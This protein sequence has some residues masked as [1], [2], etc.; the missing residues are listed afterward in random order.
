MSWHDADDFVLPAVQP[1]RFAH[2]RRIAREA[3][4]PEPMAQH[5]DLLASRLILVRRED[6]PVYRC[7]REH[8][9]EAGRRARADDA[10]GVLGVGEVEARVL[11]CRDLSERADRLDAIDEVSRAHVAAKAAQVFVDGQDSLRVR[12]RNGPQDDGVYRAEDG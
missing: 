8:V 12:N 2:D 6:A 1:N 11:D 7:G 5:D 10:L 3:T 4:G 9:E